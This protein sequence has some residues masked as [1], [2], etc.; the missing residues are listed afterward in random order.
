[1]Y[2]YLICDCDGALAVSEVI[3]YRALVEMLS[4]AFP[5]IDFTAASKA[6]FRSETPAALAGLER[7]FGI[8]LPPDF[9]ARLA[10]NI[11]SALRR[12]HAS[13]A[14]ARDVL[15]R[16][17]LPAAAV[18][19][20]RRANLA[21]A[22]ERA[23]LAG[24]FGTRLFS[25]EH[26]ARPKPHPGLYREAARQLG[27]KAAHCLAVADNVAGLNAARDAGMT[28]VAFVGA[29][30]SP[31]GYAQVLRKLGVRNIIERMDELPA[32]VAARGSGELRPS[33]Q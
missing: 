17:R 15:G 32:L 21:A 19:N 13:I 11:E 30:Q 23:G 3:A 2:D 1:M 8:T 33:Q 5:E 12:S 4:A 26:V 9:A 6:A 16:I 24:V 22:V 31:A 29:S 25:A 18:S 20:Q 14:P 27:A 7:R 28:T 10:A